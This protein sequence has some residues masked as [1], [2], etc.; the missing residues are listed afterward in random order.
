MSALPQFLWL[1]WAAWSAFA[2]VSNS[3]DR[4]GTALKA[5]IIW[6]AQIGLLYAGG[7]FS[8]FGGRN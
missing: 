1:F 5:T 6:S 4:M 2:Y 7:F 3:H 8:N